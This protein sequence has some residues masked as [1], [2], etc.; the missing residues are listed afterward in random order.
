MPEWWGIAAAISVAVAASAVAVYFYSSDEY[1][2]G[3]SCWDTIDLYTAELNMLKINTNEQR[4]YADAWEAH[5]YK[6]TLVMDETIE[7]E[8]PSGRRLQNTEKE[9]DS[10]EDH[11]MRAREKRFGTIDTVDLK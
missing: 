11:E 8:D 6:I 5:S 1:S 4:Y 2:L 7:D 3:N 10:D 9:S